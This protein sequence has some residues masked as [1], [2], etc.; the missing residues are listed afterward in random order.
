MLSATRFEKINGHVP[1][2]E[3]DRGRGKF[4]ANCACDCGENEETLFGSPARTESD[5]LRSLRDVVLTKHGRIAMAAANWRCT[6]CS[7]IRGL[8]AHHQQFRSHGRD[9]RV[10]NLVVLCQSCHVA[11]HGQVSARRT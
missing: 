6:K 11:E 9:D 2:V 10:G 5:S 7:E 3:F 1:F 4:R 8:A